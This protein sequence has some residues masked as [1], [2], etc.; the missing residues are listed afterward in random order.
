MNNATLTRLM[1]NAYVEE[2]RRAARP[3]CL[4]SSQ[5]RTGTAPTN[6]IRTLVARFAHSV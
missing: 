4:T 5:R 2:A 1:A 3:V 6:S